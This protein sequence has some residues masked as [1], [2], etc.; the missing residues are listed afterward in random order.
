MIEKLL[1][2]LRR[3]NIYILVMG[4]IILSLLLL[5]LLLFVGD[6]IYGHNVPEV[7]QA[8]SGVVFLFVASF[9][10]VFQVYR[11][12]GTGP[13]GYPVFGIWPI[14]SGCLITVICWAGITYLLIRIYNLIMTQ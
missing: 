14:I 6:S 9:S 5:G 7:Y 3:I 2:S 8:A 4:P 1:L 11:R 10:G 13:L 12:E